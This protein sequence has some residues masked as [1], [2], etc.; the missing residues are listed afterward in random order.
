MCP[1]SSKSNIFQGKRASEEKNDQAKIFTQSFYV[2][3]SIKLKRNYPMLEVILSGEPM[4]CVAVDKL[5][6]VGKND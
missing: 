6:V 1:V 4:F 3:Q 5:V 2:V